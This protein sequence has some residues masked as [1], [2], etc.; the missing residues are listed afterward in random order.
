MPGLPP[1]SA[2]W[3]MERKPAGTW[4]S[5]EKLWK[6]RKAMKR[7]KIFGIDKKI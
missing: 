2:A 4:V 6:E 5:T 3:W 7:V 1:M